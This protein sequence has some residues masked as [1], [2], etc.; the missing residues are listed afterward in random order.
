MFTFFMGNNLSPQVNQY[1]SRV[2][3]ANPT[4]YSALIAM[5]DGLVADAVWDK[6]DVLNVV[7]D[8]QAASLTNLISS[9]YAGVLTGAT[10]PTFTANRGFGS[11]GGIGVDLT[12]T[13]YIDT[14]YIANTGGAKAVDFHASLF[15]YLRKHRY[16]NSV[17]VGV[18]DGASAA[19]SHAGS[20]SVGS[21]TSYTEQ[22]NTVGAATIT[23]STSILSGFLAASRTSTTASEVRCFGLSG[24][25]S[26]SVSATI[27][28][29]SVYIGTKH[30]T[31]GAP[32]STFAGNIGAWGMGAGLSAT[33]LTNLAARINTYMT[34]IGANV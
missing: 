30:I 25:S 27:P 10:T 14:G 18:S 11:E 4:T 24:T 7:Q 32:T 26:V 2:S 33:E 20:G 9:S 5:I 34:A 21:V 28:A 13:G 8:T 16:G 15:T 22:I 17:H 19:Y 12:K 29:L 23:F 3:I 6:L 1:L 31:T